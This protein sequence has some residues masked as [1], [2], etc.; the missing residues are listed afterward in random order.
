M[1]RANRIRTLGAGGFET[2][3][4]VS[5]DKRL[6]SSMHRG[7]IERLRNMPRVISREYGRRARVVN[8][9]LV[10]LAD[11]VVRGV[12][13]FASVFD[14]D[15]GDVFGQERVEAAVEVFISEARFRGEADDLTQCMDTGVGA[16]GGGDAQTLL[17]EPLPGGLDRA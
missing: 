15:D 2:R 4:V 10:A 5:P 1:N 9:I 14:C 17:R 6:P 3:K 16:A 12:E 13:V 8:P 7:C 11:G